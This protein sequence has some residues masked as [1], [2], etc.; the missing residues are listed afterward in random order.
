MKEAKGIEGKWEG[1]RE[2]TRE[3]GKPFLFSKAIIK[4]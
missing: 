1:G 4:G 3:G 2:R